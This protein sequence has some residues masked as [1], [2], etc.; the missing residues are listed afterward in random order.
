[1]IKVSVY[2][3]I[4]GANADYGDWADAEIRWVVNTSVNFQLFNSSLICALHT[5]ELVIFDWCFC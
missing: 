1:M 2:D 3:Q 4:L 5:S